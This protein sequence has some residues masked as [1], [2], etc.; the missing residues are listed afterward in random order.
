MGSLSEH[1]KANGVLAATFFFASGWSGSIRRHGKK[2]LVTTIAHQLARYDTILREEI[3]KAIEADSD[4]FD[5]NLVTQMKSLVLGPLQRRPIEPILRGAIIIDGLD[6]CEAAAER[7]HSSTTPEVL[8][9]K[10]SQD[11]LEILQV[12]RAASSDPSFPFRILIAS[13]PERVFREFFDPERNPSFAQKLDLNEQYNADADI[14]LFLEVQFDLIRYRFRPPSGTIQTLVENAS[15]QFIYAATVIRLLTEDHQEAPEARLK[16]LLKIRKT[17]LNP[18]GQLDALYAHILR[19]SPDP[20]LSVRWIVSIGL[21]SDFNPSP[22]ASVMNTLLQTELDSNEAEHL[23]GNLHSL[24]GVPPSTDQ[25]T[26]KYSFYHKSMRDF[27]EAP[28][29]CGELYVGRREIGAFIWDAFVRGCTSEYLFSFCLC[30]C[31]SFTA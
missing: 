3:S 30:L 11:Q 20:P 1:C 16:A 17:T 15:G 23:L 25:S 21:L 13:R 9:Y 4:I 26:T 5:K 12:L 29:R 22:S 2:V 7:Y 10:S 31:F 14:T 28:D 27:L 8:S 24:I 6:E 18:L 19:S